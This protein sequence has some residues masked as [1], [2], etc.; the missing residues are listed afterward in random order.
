[1]PLQRCTSG[2]G[3]SRGCDPRWE[4]AARSERRDYPCRP[5][6]ADGLVMKRQRCFHVIAPAPT[7][8]DRL[9]ISEDIKDK[10]SYRF[11][12]ANI[13]VYGERNFSS[14]REPLARRRL[15]DYSTDGRRHKRGGLVA[16]VSICSTYEPSA[17]GLLLPAESQHTNICCHTH[18][19]RGHLATPPG[20]ARSPPSHKNLNA[21]CQAIIR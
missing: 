15:A 6:D 9:L 8:S 4:P 10:G 2:R 16:V 11:W 19:Q 14:C 18:T 17:G 7:S 1:M 3:W 21:S 13:E 20:P 12:L 5:V